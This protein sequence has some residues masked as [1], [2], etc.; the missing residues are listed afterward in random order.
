MPLTTTGYSDDDYRMNHRNV[1][2]AGAAPKILFR[3]GCIFLVLAAAVTMWEGTAR[4]TPSDDVYIDQP[5]Y[6]PDG[7]YMVVVFTDSGGGG[8]SPYCTD[9]VSVVPASLT[10][11]QGYARRFRVYTGTCHTLGFFYPLHSPPS[12]LNAPLLKWSS[13]SKL[14]ITI[15]SNQAAL[16]V[17]KS[18]L[19]ARND[20][21]LVEI[22]QKGFDKEH[23]RVAGPFNPHRMPIILK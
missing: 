13:P 2:R 19:V 20:D 5:L 11:A 23:T 15:G 3:G 14:E 10:P 21:G 7:K 4:D 9:I 22:T 12:L 8:I 17:D 16:G 6:S 18:Q 1:V